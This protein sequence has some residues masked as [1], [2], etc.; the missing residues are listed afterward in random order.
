ML[1]E[2]PGFSDWKVQIV[3]DEGTPH[4][5]FCDVFYR[6]GFGSKDETSKGEPVEIFTVMWKDSEDVLVQVRMYKNGFASMASYVPAFFE[7]DARKKTVRLT[8]NVPLDAIKGLYPKIMQ[9]ASQGD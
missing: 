4:T 1:Y 8:F 9:L 6:T 3:D 7:A 2:R 5:D